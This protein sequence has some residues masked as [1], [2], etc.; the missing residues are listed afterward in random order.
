M[1]TLNQYSFIKKL[2]FIFLSVIL[3]SCGSTQYDISERDSKNQKESY[4]SSQVVQ[5]SNKAYYHL[6]NGIQ[7]FNLPE[8]KTELATI[9]VWRKDLAPPVLTRQYAYQ[10]LMHISLSMATEAIHLE[11][12]K[13]LLH[14]LGNPQSPQQV[15]VHKS[16]YTG[17]RLHFKAQSE[18]DQGKLVDLIS[19]WVDGANQISGKALER[20]KPLLPLYLASLN[21]KE[22]MKAAAVQAYTNHLS[23]ETVEHLGIENLRDVTTQSIQEFYYPYHAGSNIKITVRG[24]TDLIGLDRLAKR[25]SQ[26]NLPVKQREKQMSLKS[27]QFGHQVVIAEEKRFSED[28]LAA[29][30]PLSGPNN[31]SSQA[32]L[33]EYAAQLSLV[34]DIETG[35]KLICQ[36]NSSRDCNYQVDVVNIPGSDSN[37]LFIY[38]RDIKNF[39]QAITQLD[40]ELEQLALNPFRNKIQLQP[41]DIIDLLLNANSSAELQR[42]RAF[43]QGRKEVAPSDNHTSISQ[44]LKRPSILS[45]IGLEESST[46]PDLKSI[47]RSLDNAKE[48]PTKEPQ[49]VIPALQDITARE[50][51]AQSSTQDNGVYKWKL[52]NGAQVYLLSSDQGGEQID[53][54]G[55]S[56]GG[57]TLIS[58]DILS[59]ATYLAPTLLKLGTNELKGKYDNFYL[60]ANNLEFSAQLN[61]FTENVE[62]SFPTSRAESFF[63]YL[64]YFFNGLKKDFPTIQ[65]ALSERADQIKNSRI[66]VEQK[67]SN[68][69][70]SLQNLKDPR[71]VPA[72]SAKDLKTIKLAEAH[73]ALTKRWNNIGA[74]QLFFSGD[75]P[76][77]K[78]AELIET[79]LGGLEGTDQVPNYLTFPWRAGH[80]TDLTVQL[81]PSADYSRIRILWEGELDDFTF[82]DRQQLQII[83]TILEMRLQERLGEKINIAYSIDATAT[84]SR[85]DYPHYQI[86]IETIVPTGNVK[87]VTKWVNDI[88]TSLK[89]LGATETEVNTAKRLLLTEYLLCK[90]EQECW[91]NLRMQAN[92]ERE[93]W[94]KYQNYPDL[95]DKIGFEN[96]NRIIQRYLD[97][98]MFTVSVGIK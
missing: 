58:E 62:G 64:H 30:I 51:S 28:A 39:N 12:T 14:K 73:E 69:L 67:L 81:N 47:Y 38:R 72:P 20:A 97:D 65:R 6:P 7:M 85:I 8:E 95:L 27:L 61:H 74:F 19:T 71:S 36:E 92:M 35:L 63:K 50:G 93:D 96:I 33:T 5:S 26:L 42:I 84:M 23:D 2:I 76:A 48:E 82:K 1:T 86:N 31:Q 66:P 49:L 41:A 98:T 55:F 78:M 17:L 32:V 56:F 40:S 52:Q 3:F 9:T 80:D 10:A 18:E 75:I 44:L 11:Q 59:D 79:Y 25:L 16:G 68:A 21:N 43:Y 90:R 87:T 57:K 83:A 88:K 4:K 54:K 89:Q 13:D 60:Q 29:V 37:I 77:E 46:V 45:V 15:I 70:D 53:F 22:N 91:L 34:Q 24:A 94:E